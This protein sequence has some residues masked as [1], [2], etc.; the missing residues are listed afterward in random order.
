MCDNLTHLFNMYVVFVYNVYRFCA[1]FTKYVLMNGRKVSPEDVFRAINNC[2][3]LY[4]GWTIGVRF[5]AEAESWIFVT[6][7]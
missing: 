6:T 5:A 7:L 3:A 4:V 1:Y 2:I